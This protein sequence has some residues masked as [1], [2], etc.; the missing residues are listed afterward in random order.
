MINRTK[1]RGRVSV[2]RCL[3]AFFTFGLSLPFLGVRKPG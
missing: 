3:I 2:T 1:V